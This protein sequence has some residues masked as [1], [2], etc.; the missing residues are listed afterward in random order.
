MEFNGRLGRHIMDR[1]TDISNSSSSSQ[2]SQQVGNVAI[3]Y[4]GCVVLLAIL[5]HQELDAG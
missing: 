3:N 5:Y 1:A 2:A 4:I